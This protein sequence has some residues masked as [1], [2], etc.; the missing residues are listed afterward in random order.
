MLFSVSG[1]FMPE[2]TEVPVASLDSVTPG[3]VNPQTVYR[4][5]E[6]DEKGILFRAGGWRSA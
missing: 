4:T 3:G 5:T 2:A 6:N 1:L